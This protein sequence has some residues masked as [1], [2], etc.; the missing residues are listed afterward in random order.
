[1]R[2]AFNYLFYTSYRIMRFLG[3]DGFFLE[4]MAY[5]LTASLV[6]L[7]FLTVLYILKITTGKDILN[8]PT[9]VVIYI[10]Y[11]GTCY[12]YFFYRD[13]YESYIEVSEK[14]RKKGKDILMAIYFV[15]SLA[16][17]FYLQDMVRQN[18]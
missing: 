6:W 16:L 7:N 5:I 2:S 4:G 14:A 1:M 3:H 10:V 13:R 17:H 12:Y 9:T 8:F 15:A 18:L 11:L